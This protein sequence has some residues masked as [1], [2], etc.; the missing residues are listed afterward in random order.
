[1]SGT[2]MSIQQLRYIII[3]GIRKSRTLRSVHMS[4][5]NL[6]TIKR[7]LVREAMRTIKIEVDHSIK[8]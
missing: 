8:D 5:M 6:T 3:N 4:Q 7:R 1:M 2:N